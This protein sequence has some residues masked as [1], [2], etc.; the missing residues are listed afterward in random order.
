MSLSLIDVDEVH[1]I[2]LLDRVARR[3]NNRLNP[4]DLAERQAGCPGRE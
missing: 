4:F 2:L 3:F 1:R